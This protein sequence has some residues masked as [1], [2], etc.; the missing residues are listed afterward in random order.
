[1]VV[2]VTAVLTEVVPTAVSA[3]VISLSGVVVAGRVT[4]TWLVRVEVL[5]YV[6]VNGWTAVTVMYEIEV[7]VDGLE[8]QAQVMGSVAAAVAASMAVVKNC[9]KC[10]MNVE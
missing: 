4:V 5:V 2:S 9:F 8:L 10:M 6:V 3:P 1:L 7:T